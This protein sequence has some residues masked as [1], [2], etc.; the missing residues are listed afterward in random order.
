MH[1]KADVILPTVHV[2]S[3]R[4][5]FIV[6]VLN[7]ILLPVEALRKSTSWYDLWSADNK[8]C[9]EMK[10]FPEIDPALRE[11]FQDKDNSHHASSLARSFFPLFHPM[12][13]TFG[14]NDLSS[15]LWEKYKLLVGTISS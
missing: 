11:F 9:L 2:Y 1:F 5:T 14:W 3:G 13:E 8:S 7:I 4:L 15:I 12:R 10:L 6:A